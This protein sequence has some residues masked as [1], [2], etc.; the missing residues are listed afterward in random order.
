MVKY[1]WVKKQV[2]I[3]S[4]SNGEVQQV[5]L[6]EIENA[7]AEEPGTKIDKMFPWME[8]LLEAKWSGRESLIEVAVPDDFAEDDEPPVIERGPV[9]MELQVFY[10]VYT[11]VKSV[12][13]TAQSV[14]YNAI[15]NAFNHF[16]Q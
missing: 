14:K 2:N 12:T 7:V 16:S 11:L 1:D 4:T 8:S 5:S 10:V 13:P 9:V 3:L 15:K 6:K